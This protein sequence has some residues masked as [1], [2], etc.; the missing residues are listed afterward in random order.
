MLTEM[1]ADPVL[2]NVPV[3]MLTMIKQGSDI[4]RAYKGGAC[5]FIAKPVSFDT[6]QSVAR[7]FAL[8]W[9]TVADIPQGEDLDVLLA[10]V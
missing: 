2:S 5:S 7:Q 6:M 4:L 8:Y 3:V 9:T 10:L 1:R